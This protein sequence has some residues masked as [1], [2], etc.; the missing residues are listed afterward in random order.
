MSGRRVRDD[1]DLERECHELPHPQK[2]DGHAGRF[3]MP[4]QRRNDGAVATNANPAKLGMTTGAQ[5]DGPRAEC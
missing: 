1:L 4:A 2:L 5:L 3:S